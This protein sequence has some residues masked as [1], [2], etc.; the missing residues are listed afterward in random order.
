MDA[1]CGNWLELG[2]ETGDVHVGFDVAD[3][4]V[5]VR[6]ELADVEVAQVDGCSVRV[7]L[8]TRAS[9]SRWPP[10]CPRTP[11]SGSA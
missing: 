3:L 10:R 9:R 4:D 2:K 6:N 1:E 5:A 8:G 7:R 11:P